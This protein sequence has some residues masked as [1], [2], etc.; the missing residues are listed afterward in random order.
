VVQSSLISGAGGSGISAM[1]TGS[2]S[3]PG[4]SAIAPDQ[5]GLIMQWWLKDIALPITRSCLM[6]GAL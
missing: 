4:V 2:P 3:T 1:G 6:G 5:Q